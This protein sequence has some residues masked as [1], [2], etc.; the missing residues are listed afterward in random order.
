MNILSEMKRTLFIAAL[1]IIPLTAGLARGEEYLPDSM[2]THPEWYI[3][4]SD[5]SVYATWGG[6]AIIQGLTIENTS[7]LAYTGVKVRV[8]YTSSAAGGAGGVVNQESGVLPI[9]LPPKSKDTYLKA[10][11]PF[12]AGSQFMNP[13]AI[14]VLG[15]TPVLD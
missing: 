3:N 13:L 11:Y 12:G 2:K 1:L 14:Q 7:D 5:W 8:T 10:G 15:A 6:V 9:T 4:I